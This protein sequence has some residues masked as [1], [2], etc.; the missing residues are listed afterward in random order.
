M[1]YR[2]KIFPIKT[3]GKMAAPNFEAKNTI[4]ANSSVC[5]LLW[6]AEKLVP[7]QTNLERSKRKKG[8][9]R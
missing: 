7:T 2:V 5:H 6:V 1:F 9:I 8:R 3:E 4:T